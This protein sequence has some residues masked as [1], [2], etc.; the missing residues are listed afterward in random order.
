MSFSECFH[1]VC[2]RHQAH[3]AY[4]YPLM[5]D[6]AVRASYV[7]LSTYDR[8][9]CVHEPPLRKHGDRKAVGCLNC[10][11][12]GVALVGQGASTLDAKDVHC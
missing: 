6:E 2:A 12:T 1:A 9:A 3:T 8:D 4:S 11:M 5:A 10:S 7:L